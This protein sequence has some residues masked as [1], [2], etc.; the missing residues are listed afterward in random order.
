[1]S[2]RKCLSCGLEA[3]TKDDL[4]LFIKHKKG[5]YGREN[6]CKRCK[7]KEFLNWRQ[8]NPDY[9][10]TYHQINLEKERENSKR[11]IS[12]N[13]SKALHNSR[14]YQLTKKSATPVWA[15]LEQIKNIYMKA[16]VS[17]KEVDH[18]IPIQNSLVCGLHVHNNLQLLSKEEN[19]S[20][21]NKYKVA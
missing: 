7:P 3:L 4:D 14:K 12:E 9:R 1:M 10:K 11:W 6:K 21:S 18:V 16:E 19:R 15:D 5:L 13:K 2:L 8:E 17:K 20:K